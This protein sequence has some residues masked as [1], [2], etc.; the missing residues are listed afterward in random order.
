MP[1]GF[2][3][4]SGGYHNFGGEDLEAPA[5]APPVHAPSQPE[6]QP[7]APVPGGYQTVN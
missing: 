7:A 5:A 3:Q 4:N 6:A 1:G 2:N